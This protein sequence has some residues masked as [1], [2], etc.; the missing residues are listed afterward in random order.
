[1]LAD[2]GRL[3]FHLATTNAAK[4]IDAIVEHFYTWKEARHQIRPWFS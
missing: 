3:F 2:R 1:V 4:R